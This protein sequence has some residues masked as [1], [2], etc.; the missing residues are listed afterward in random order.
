MVSP[1]FH[2]LKSAI[3]E[4]KEIESWR[5]GGSISY[6]KTSEGE[7]MITRYEPNEVEIDVDGEKD[8]FLVLADMHYPGWKVYIDGDKGRI[9]Q[10]DYIFRGVRM[11]AGRHKVLFRYEPLSYRLGFL[12]TILTIPFLTISLFCRKKIREKLDKNAKL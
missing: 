7:A 12:I 10:T 1:D 2:F 11:P 6:I 4:S 3:I 9:F 5:A 8:S